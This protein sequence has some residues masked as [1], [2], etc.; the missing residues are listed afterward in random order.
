MYRKTRIVLKNYNY[1]S[2][3]F[4]TIMIFYFIYGNCL[5]SSTNSSYTSEKGLTGTIGLGRSQQSK[6][7][8]KTAQIVKAA[9]GGYINYF[10]EP[11]GHENI[12][13]VSNTPIKY[14]SDGIDFKEGLTVDKYQILIRNIVEKKNPDLNPESAD[15]KYFFR[16][17][18]ENLYSLNGYLPANKFNSIVDARAIYLKVNI[19]IDT[20]KVKPE[21]KKSLKQLYIIACIYM[22]KIRQSEASLQK[23]KK[24]PSD[25]ILF[26][27]KNYKSM[28]TLGE[29][30]A[31]MAGE[32]LYYICCAF[33]NKFTDLPKEKQMEV[34]DRIYSFNP[35]LEIASQ[36]IPHY[37]FSYWILSILPSKVKPKLLKYCVAGN[38]GWLILPININ[39]N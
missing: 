8:I 19:Y 39:L 5:F 7:T 16:A 27:L 31:G 1:K 9:K 20:L 33:Y 10:E 37:N 36:I 21:I 38:I 29:Y 32:N 30:T 22:Q 12:S 17:L 25:S 18:A 35:T 13:L 14:I 4:A 6:S 15:S 3:F 24:I 28:S 23:L 11:H 34:L 2:S 26:E